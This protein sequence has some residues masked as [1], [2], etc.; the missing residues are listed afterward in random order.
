MSF[1]IQRSK[2]G[3]RKRLIPLLFIVAVVVAILYL[4]AKK[5]LPS[6]VP[7]GV[8]TVDVDVATNAAK[9]VKVELPKGRPVALSD[10][11]VVRLLVM[12]W[13]AQSS[14][15]LANGGPVTTIDSKVAKRGAQLRI[16]NENDTDQMKDQLIAGVTEWARNGGSGNPTNGAHGVIFMGDGIPGYLPGWNEA[17]RKVCRAYKLPEEQCE[18]RVIGAV[19][20]SYGEDKHMVPVEWKN[21]PRQALASVSGRYEL[22]AAY[23]WD[24]DHVLGLDWAAAN[25]LPV[26]P[27]DKTF[28][29]DAVN[30]MNP[31][32]YLDAVDKYLAGYCETRE[33]V[34]HGKASGRKVQ[35]CVAA[36]DTWT[37]GDWNVAHSAKDTLV[38]ALSTRENRN[39]MASTLV[40]PNGWARQHAESI[41][42]IL[43]AN[44][45]AADMIKVSDLALHRAAVIATQIYGGKANLTADEW[46]AL[47]KG[48][49]HRTKN[50]Y[51][52]TLG[53]S[54]VWNL[55]DNLDYYGLS[56]ETN[57][58]DAVYTNIGQMISKLAPNVIPKLRPLSEVF[59]P[60][61]LL[62]AKAML[63]EGGLGVAEVPHYTGGAISDVVASRPYTINFDPGSD[64]I[65]A[66]SMET[67]RELYQQVA[68]SDLKV[69][70]VGHT[71]NTGG[72][73]FNNQAL[74]ERRAAAVKTAIIAAS[75]GSKFLPETRFSTEGRGASEPVNPE[76]NQNSATERALNRRVVITLGR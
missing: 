57:I 28:D 62:H 26:N 71:D 47:F 65:Q 39:Q 66:G 21:D 35:A 17:L 1:E 37:P 51:Q 30:F 25:G 60:S 58:Y 67:I 33:L 31:K 2:G 11:K 41:A 55:A 6:L 76:A 36:V 20:S 44:S 59:D 12:Q 18:V 68:K 14:L 9:N 73:N 4:P 16:V 34:S 5:I 45:E 15:F 19:G 42:A 56:G 70:I 23:F 22:T 24:G 7:S 74:S 38:T 61:Y 69:S 8:K 63:G 43:A 46:A 64:R 49:P 13:G 75:H 3:F 72:P 53:G 32:D 27:S 48:V 29:P 40:V 50:G 54:R 10:E 52:I